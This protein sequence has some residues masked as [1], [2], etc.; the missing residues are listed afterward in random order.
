M[1]EHLDYA[2]AMLTSMSYEGSI[3]LM[4][5]SNLLASLFLRLNKAKE[6]LLA[7]NT[8]TSPYSSLHFIP[9][10]EM[11][12]VEESEL[13]TNNFL[14]STYSNQRYFYAPASN[15]ATS[16]ISIVHQ[17]IKII[18]NFS[19]LKENQPYIAQTPGIL[20]LLLYLLS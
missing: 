15:S 14:S 8:S 16:N 6:A 12:K 4:P 7:T 11:P 9:S 19:A 18:Y 5:Q 3:V 2:L 13:E 20:Q 17:I 10:S 1:D